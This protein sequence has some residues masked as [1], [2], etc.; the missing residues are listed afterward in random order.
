MAGR[1]RPTITTC[2]PMRRT[3]RSV[4]RF[5]FQAAS[6]YADEWRSMSVSPLGTDL[7]KT[8]SQTKIDAYMI[9]IV[10]FSFP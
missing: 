10:M 1:F 4:R 8:L 7:R 9:I 2:N 3:E 6:V 5:G